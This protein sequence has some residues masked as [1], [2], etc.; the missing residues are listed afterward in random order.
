[1]GCGVGVHGEIPHAGL[2]TGFFGCSA[3]GLN[4]VDVVGWLPFVG[5]RS[6][7]RRQLEL[8]DARS[9]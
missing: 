9:L 3:R 4:Q 2:N 5:R 6:K 7:S 1:M 8:K